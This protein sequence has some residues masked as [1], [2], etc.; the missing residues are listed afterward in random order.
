MTQPFLPN[1]A[2][3]FN[4]NQAEPDSVDFEILLLAYQRTGVISG[5]AVSESSPA[6]QTVDVA[7]GEVVETGEQITVSAQ[8]GVAVSAADGTNPRFDL[9]TLN[10]AGTVVVT[11]GTAAAQPVMPAVPATSIP[12]ATLFIAASDNTH[13][14]NQINDKR[15]LVADRYVF[16]VKDFGATG[17]GTTDDSTAVQAAADA[18]TS[19]GIL[20]FPPGTYV[21]RFNLNEDGIWVLGSGRQA[22][23]LKLPDSSPI[24]VAVIDGEAGQTRFAVTI[25]NL[26]IDGNKANQSLDNWGI[27]VFRANQW[28]LMNLHVKDTQGNGIRF[29]GENGALTLDCYLGY[30]RIEGTG[31]TAIDIGGFAPNNHIDHNVVGGTDNF[32]CI[33]VQNVEAIL[34]GNHCHS[35]A[36]HGIRVNSNDAVLVGNITESNTDTGLLIESTANGTRISSHSSHDNTAAEYALDGI[37]TRFETVPTEVA[38]AVILDWSHGVVNME[39]TAATRTVTLPDNADFN[40]KSY[41]IRRDGSNTVT[42]DRAGADTFDDADVQKTLD[43]DSAAIGIFSIGDGEWKIVATEGTVG[44]S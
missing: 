35:A 7:L 12:L 18:M 38:A 1:E 44:G 21:C 13:A 9:I 8:A 36:R 28:R 22:T 10:S 40:G 41:L 19:G 14:N 31:T 15:V 30:S 33:E 25:S 43:T 42:I 24:S 34:T 20:F 23:I 4:A 5:C 32:D 3:A 6:A 29:Q 26:T 16:N 39:S 2:D 37:D 27:R 11:A 17:D